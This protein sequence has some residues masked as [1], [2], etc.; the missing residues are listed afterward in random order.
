MAENLFEWR[1]EYLIGVDELDYEHRDMMKRLNQLYREVLAGSEAMVIERC[2][3]SIYTRMG[4]H[5]ALE[6]KYMRDTDFGK[7]HEH[8]EEHD[9]FLEDLFDMVELFGQK[10]EFSYL[11]TLAVRLEGWV[12]QHIL[13]S[14]KELN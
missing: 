6:E 4:A 10:Q 13:S 1:E 8:K 7:Y 11:E 2:L 9:A 14:D 12:T 5:F 3:G